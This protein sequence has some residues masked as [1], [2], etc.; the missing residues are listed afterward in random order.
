M[1]KNKK[2]F[3]LLSI[4]VSSL[5]LTNN[6]MIYNNSKE[7]SI[8]QNSRKDSFDWGEPSYRGGLWFSRPII[9]NVYLDLST[10]EKDD[11]KMDVS[12]FAKKGSGEQT[13]N[14]LVK[15][16]EV[17]ESG[18]Q[19]GEIIGQSEYVRTYGRV[20]RLTS[21][22]ITFGGLKE[23]KKYK[24]QSYASGYGSNSA[25]YVTFSPYNSVKNFDYN[26]DMNFLETSMTSSMDLNFSFDLEEGDYLKDEVNLVFFRPSDFLPKEN[27]LS[28]NGKFYEAEDYDVI[29]DRENIFVDNNISLQETVNSNNHFEY[30]I[31]VEDLEKIGSLYSNFYIK[32][33]TNNNFEYYKNNVSFSGTNSGVDKENFQNFYFNI[34]FKTKYLIDG[35]SIID[36]SKT[37]TNLKFDINSTNFGLYSDQERT[38]SIDYDRETILDGGGIETDSGTWNDLLIDK[39]GDLFIDG[40]IEHSNYTIKNINYNDGLNLV[41]DSTNGEIIETQFESLF[42]VNETFKIDEITKNSLKFSLNVFDEGDSNFINQYDFIYLFFKNDKEG[43]SPLIAYRLNDG[44]GSGEEKTYQFEVRNLSS[45]TEYEL[46]GL[47][48]DKNFGFDGEGNDESFVG[49]GLENVVIETNIDE[50]ESKGYIYIILV[51]GLLLILVFIL[52][53]FLFIK[54]IRKS[55]MFSEAKGQ[56]G[57]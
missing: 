48:L 27:D 5:L 35:Y 39:N 1:K 21:N 49:N 44:S 47:S 26:Y 56:Y 28:D 22:M 19:I 7:N 10:P 40:L 18:N 24:L 12:I 3:S 53:M 8:K 23:G 38:I 33:N 31:H 2:F 9:K 15:F 50:I 14:S 57:I 45:G 11:Y 55:K 54:N 4:L 36:T 34:P 52:F 16:W 41:I 37:S 43:D 51:V 13:I 25:N 29:E 42:L 17:D 32:I 46:L 30:K 20:D 6:E